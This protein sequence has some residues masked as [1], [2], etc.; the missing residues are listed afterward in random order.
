MDEVIIEKVNDVYVRIQAEPSTKMEL[1]DH[2]T[3]K[4]PGAEFM[5]AYRNKIWDG[6]IRLL[7]LMTGM[8]YRGLVPY[9]LNFCNSRDYPVTV[10]EGIVPN[11]EVQDTAGYDLAKEFES[12]FTP[13]EYQNDAVVHALKHE[14]ALLLSPTASGKSFIIYLLTRFYTETLGIK[15]LIVVPTTSLVEQM[16]N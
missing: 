16:K 3:F 13:R 7:N 1:S 15:V 5:P 10:D 14:R 9:I 12:V 2:F 6:K 8:I 11:N 4:V